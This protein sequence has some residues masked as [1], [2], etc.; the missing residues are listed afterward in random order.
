MND[1]GYSSNK[2][3]HI[4]EIK[5]KQKVIECKKEYDLAARDRLLKD[6]LLEQT[7]LYREYR[8]SFNVFIIMGY[9]T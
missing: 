6:Y 9:C 5:I 1:S 4:W 8:K 3:L 2:M 7:R